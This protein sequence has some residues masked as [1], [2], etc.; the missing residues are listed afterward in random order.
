MRR[1]RTATIGLLAVFLLFGDAFAPGTLEAQAAVS[2]Y[3]SQWLRYMQSRMQFGIRAGRITMTTSRSG[4]FSSSWTP[5]KNGHKEKLS[6]KS[7]WRSGNTTLNYESVAP[8]TSLKM[9]ASNTGFFRIVREPGEKGEKTVPSEFVQDRAGG[10]TL[11]YGEGDAKTIVKAPTIWRLLLA[12]REPCE[13]YVLPSLELLFKK[14]NL[15]DEADKIEKELLAAAKAGKL[16]NR[17]EWDE[18]VKQLG[19]DSYARRQAADRRL[20]AFGPPVAAYL[21]SLNRKKLDAE[22]QMRIHRILESFAV[23]VDDET[24]ADRA[25]MML[26]DPM[27][28]LILME[29][30]DEKTRVLA[31]GQLE[32]LL[33]RPIDF[34]PKAK[35][36]KRKEQVKYLRKEIAEE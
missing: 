9:T 26:G 28:W 17:R 31:A 1:I 10:Y 4:S 22:Q 21:R 7:D 18:L 14:T 29:R 36:A 25:E 13:K 6:V 15:G 30:D 27:I 5:G 24:P 8:E 16:P 12:H 11:T 23:Q 35:K 33:G 3:R 20:R 2:R 32:R 19:D 34:D